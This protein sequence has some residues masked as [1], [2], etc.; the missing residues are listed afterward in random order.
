MSGN[1]E[2][3]TKGYPD[4][5]GRVNSD[6]LLPFRTVTRSG[7]PYSES[8]GVW[9]E[10]LDVVFDGYFRYLL[11]TGP[12]RSD[13]THASPWFASF[14]GLSPSYSYR[15]LPSGRPLTSRLLSQLL[16]HVPFRPGS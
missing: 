16:R 13:L 7:R 3:T 9:I 2:T 10:V 8:S 1:T 6:Y 12:G 11:G 4:Q 5:E 15:L 14:K